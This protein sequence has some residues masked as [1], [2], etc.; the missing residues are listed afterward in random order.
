MDIALFILAVFQFLVIRKLKI[1]NDALKSRIQS[2]NQ[3][4]EFRQ[5]LLD[6]AESFSKI[7]I[8]D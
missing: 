7:E 8:L 2:R 4:I 6:N 3:A 1:E 5:F